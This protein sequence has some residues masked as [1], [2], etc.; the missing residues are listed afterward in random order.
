[1]D[2]LWGD[3]QPVVRVICVVEGDFLSGISVAIARKLEG[4]PKVP[5]CHL[6][7]TPQ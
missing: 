5:K 3:E 7:E 1:M 6:L 2:G 4:E